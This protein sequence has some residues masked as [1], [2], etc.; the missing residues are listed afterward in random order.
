[1]STRQATTGS[2]SVEGRWVLEA[3]DRFEKPLILYATR[4][5]GDPERARD[6]VQDTFLKLCKQPR[7]EI[8]DRLGE[9]LFSV[10]RN[11]AV[12]VMRKEKRM[13]FLSDERAMICASTEPD[14]AELTAERDAAQQAMDLLNSLPANQQEVIRLKFQHGF[15]Y[16]DISQ[17]TGHSVSNVGFLIHTGMK[18]LQKRLGRRLATSG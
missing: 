6:V 16:R 1:M 9:W 12:D 15:S 4:L 2:H 17:I 14:P 8:Q 18:T 7:E 10:C 3:F 13:S 11:R 5:L